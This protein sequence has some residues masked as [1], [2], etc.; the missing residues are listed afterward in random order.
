MTPQYWRS[1]G[2]RKRLIIRYSPLVPCTSLTSQGRGSTGPPE[3]RAATRLWVA[4]WSVH[5]FNFL[6]LWRRR[7]PF[8]FSP[9][10]RMPLNLPYPQLR[11]FSTKFDKF[12]LY[13]GRPNP[14]HKQ[15]LIPTLGSY[16]KRFNVGSTRAGIKPVGNIQPDLVIVA[17]DTPASG[18]AV[19]TKN[20]FLC[21]FCDCQ[22]QAYMPNQWC[23]TTRSDYI[24]QS[25]R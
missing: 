15:R 6:S 16:S 20:E 9:L 18:A 17:S 22:P 24:N 14:A 11:G 7:V 23:W 1:L 8:A 19:F 5:I 3:P 4:F 21:C 2:N 13:W 10:S 12:E 25:V